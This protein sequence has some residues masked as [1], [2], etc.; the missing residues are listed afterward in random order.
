MVGVESSCSTMV[1]YGP[2]IVFVEGF[3]ADLSGFLASLCVI[4]YKYQLNR[5]QIFKKTKCTH[6]VGE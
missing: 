6:F 1:G 3:G 2:R 5:L 4:S